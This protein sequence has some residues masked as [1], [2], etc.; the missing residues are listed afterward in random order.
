MLEESRRWQELG[1]HEADLQCA[2]QA[3]LPAGVGGRRKNT[4]AC[5]T[6]LRSCSTA[7]V[8]VWEGTRGT[9]SQGLGKRSDGGNLGHV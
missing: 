2:S 1:K 5:V 9:L 7:V 4:H 6:F 3:R 8:A